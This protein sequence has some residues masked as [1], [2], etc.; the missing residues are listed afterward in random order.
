MTG[1]TQS[2]SPDTELVILRALAKLN[3]ISGVLLKE[4]AENDRQSGAALKALPAIAKFIQTETGEIKELI[5]DQS[6]SEDDQETKELRESVKKSLANDRLITKAIIKLN[7][8]TQLLLRDVN[9]TTSAVTSTLPEALTKLIRTETKK[10]RKMIDTQ[11]TAIVDILQ[12]SEN[13][14]RAEKVIKEAQNIKK[15]F[16]RDDNKNEVEGSSSNILVKSLGPI[17]NK[18]GDNSEEAGG[19]TSRKQQLIEI[20]TPLLSKKDDQDIEEDYDE[21]DNSK[22]SDGA[23][24]AQL[25]GQKS[26]IKAL[27]KLTN[28]TRTLLEKQESE[29]E[30]PKQGGKSLKETVRGKGFDSEEYYDDYD[31]YDEE[32][33]ERTL[34]GK[35]AGSSKDLDERSGTKHLFEEFVKLAIERQ[36]WEQAQDITQIIRTSGRK[37]PIGFDYS[38]YDDYYGD[39]L[40][41]SRPKRPNRPRRPPDSY[42]NCKYD[43]QYKVFYDCDKSKEDS[44]SDETSEESGSHSRDSGDRDFRGDSRKKS[45]TKRP[46]RQKQN[47]NSRPKPSTRL[48]PNKRTTT[49][50][51]PFSDEDLEYEDSE[52]YDYPEE[53][54]EEK[55]LS[56]EEKSDEAFRSTQLNARN[57][58]LRNRS[59]AQKNKNSFQAESRPKQ[60]TQKEEVRDHDDEQEEY[61]ESYDYDELYPQEEE[62]EAIPPAPPSTTTT[63]RPPATR[64]PPPKL[65]FTR[66]RRPPP[67]TPRAITRAP[68]T[69]PSTTTFRDTSTFRPSTT[70]ERATRDNL[71]LEKERTEPPKVKTP[72][73][74][75]LATSKKS[76]RTTTESSDRSEEVFGDINNRP[77]RPVVKRP[78][79]TTQKANTLPTAKTSE[80]PRSILVKLVKSQQKS[81]VPRNSIDFQ[82]EATEA[83]RED[84]HREI[85]KVEVTKSVSEENPR[86][87]HLPIRRPQGSRQDTS[88]PRRLPPPRPGRPRRPPSA[89]RRE[90]AT[91]LA[92]EE[93]TAAAAPAKS[94]A[95]SREKSKEDA[96]RQH[97]ASHDEARRR[98]SLKRLFGHAR[99][100]SENTVGHGI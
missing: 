76:T 48:R 52:Y 40:R 85:V 4:Q 7:D 86:R 24:K 16:L 25:T 49:T 22:E 17:L 47:K 77:Q 13:L 72:L 78:E 6:S 96:T 75:L 60:K 35:I 61:S 42:E 70:S 27:I 99:N 45:P 91:T 92:P 68:S 93:K 95:G 54:S 33:D 12:E 98:N 32:S 90:S 31:Y 63:R 81:E 26:I 2:L 100:R 53:V 71:L 46:S 11:N 51:K 20:L 82:N 19:R 84:A 8:I 1:N 74:V 79:T 38:D 44:D 80:D 30:S 83:P 55:F 39:R 28:I 9:F 67:T 89:A 88:G 36:R 21:E 10:I 73:A 18:L 37:R 69:T 59:K 58:F 50:E 41:P 15:T 87:L 34:V 65:H 64:R 3:K 56:G 43:R 66:P 5:A 57:H 62:E 97:E 14:A 94:E 23:L 29:E